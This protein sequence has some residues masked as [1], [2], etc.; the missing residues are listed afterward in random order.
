MPE[1]LDDAELEHYMRETL[2]RVESLRTGETL[3]EVVPESPR[4]H[5]AA[6][7]GRVRVIVRAGAV[8]SVVLE[9]RLLRL[10]PQKLAELV[11]EAVNA[12]IDG[13]LDASTTSSTPTPDLVTLAKALH[14]AG[15]EALHRMDVIAQSIAEA[16]ARIRER[17]SISG[18]P[19]PRGLEDLI[20]MTR[21]N[22]D[23]AMAGMEATTE[24]VR[25]EGVAGRGHVRVVVSD[26]RVESVGIHPKAMAGGSHELAEQL[27]E[28][29][30][31]AFD[32]LARAGARQ[33]QGAAGVD[34]AEVARRARETQ[35][36]GIAQ[37]HA[38]T[39]ALRDIMTSIQEPE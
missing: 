1:P 7:D 34:L 39:R 16:M 24:P 33:H 3:P 21:S 27:R 36:A 35:S 38:A 32:D 5:G 13:L 19:Y 2:A 11:R 14:E 31:A 12:A 20:E 6:E 9:P 18:D 37:M 29:M 8:E 22:L 17:T 10:P 15:N 23:R 4:A 30:N 25:G 28:A 26:G